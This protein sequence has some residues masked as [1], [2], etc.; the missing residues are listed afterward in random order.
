M[1]FSLSIAFFVYTFATIAQVSFSLDTQFVA[2]GAQ[3]VYLDH[4]DQLYVVHANTIKKYNQKGVYLKEYNNP[5]RGNI[6]YINVFN[7][8]NILVFYP[9]YNEYIFLDNF[10]NQNLNT[11]LPSQNGFYDVQL[12]STVDQNAIWFYNQVDDK[13]HR[14]SLTDNTSLTSSLQINQILPTDQRPDFIYSTITNVY[15]NYKEKGIMVFDNFGGFDRLLPITGLNKFGLSETGVIYVK[16]SL[17]IELNLF[18]KQEIKT[19][20]PISGFVDYSSNDK[21]LIILKNEQIYIY[22]KD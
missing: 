5:S 1:K 17:L 12:T 4:F 14:W 13:L 7:P 19:R 20:L 10:L 22:S 18:T 3:Q 2:N 15:L 21:Y 11:F 8:M 16:D 9:E 6:G